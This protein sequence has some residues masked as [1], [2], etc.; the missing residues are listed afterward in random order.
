M[1]PEPTKEQ[2]ELWLAELAP[3]LRPVA[4]RYGHKV[5]VLAINVCMANQAMMQLAHIERETINRLT[6]LHARKAVAG[7]SQAMG[8]TKKMLHGVITQLVETSRAAQNFPPEVL[9][10]CITDINNAMRLRNAQPQP[11][12][13]GIILPN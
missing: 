11:S 1:K 10:S 12:P 13:S 5:Y 2:I 3:E 9:K 8:E 7:Y 6:T 4:Q